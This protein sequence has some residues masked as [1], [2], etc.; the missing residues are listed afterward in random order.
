MA[1]AY[2]KKVHRRHFEVGQLVL[3]RILPH[4]EEAKRKL[5]PNWQSSYLIK[6][7]LSKEA[8]H[9]IDVEG[10]FTAIIVNVMKS[11]DTTSNAF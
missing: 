10:K 7:V 5:V 3:K 2:N 4:Q 11:K 1:R 6:D 9:H 8:L